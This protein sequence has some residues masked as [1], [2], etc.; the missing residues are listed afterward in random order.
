MNKV[1]LWI[2]AILI[3]IAAAYLLFTR[4]GSAPVA[5]NAT[6]T[7]QNATSMS[8]S[9][10]SEETVDY[11]VKADI[12]QFGI[13]AIDA[14]IKNEITGQANQLKQQATQDKPT[15]VQSEKY[16]F[17]SMIS[18][19]YVGPDVVSAKV[20]ASIDTGGAH[21]MPN[22]EGFNYDRATGHALTLDDALKMTGL[23]LAQVSAQATAQLN[24]DFG[25]FVIDPQGSAPTPDNYQ[26]FYVTK[27]SVI[28][29]FEPY[30]VTAYAAGAP[31]VS[32]PR[33][34]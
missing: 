23:S 21:P 1:V 28:F 15:T 8:T 7:T 29:I 14:A 26:N 30:Q 31:E 5:Q 25:D 6:T 22:I 24:K 27:D 9:T 4:T 13:P 32:F 3:V 18:S 34:K 2:L 10:I 33:V 20:V 19:T 17:D 16:E 11:I 12:P